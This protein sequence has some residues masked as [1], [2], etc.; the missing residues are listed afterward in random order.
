MINKWLLVI[1]TLGINDGY[2]RTNWENKQAFHF[3]KLN[4]ANRVIANVYIYTLRSV[5]LL[6]WR[7]TSKS[8]SR[9][10]G[11]VKVKTGGNFDTLSLTGI[12]SW[13]FAWGVSQK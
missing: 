11:R 12:E 4:E 2:E 5:W 3:D 8:L 13:T 1:N 10:R 7:Q 9:F 6:L